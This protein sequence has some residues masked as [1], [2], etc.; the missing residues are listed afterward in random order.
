M[1]LAFFV[2]RGVSE[3][4][5]LESLWNAETAYEY[6]VKWSGGKLTKN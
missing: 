6:F 1:H 5:E 4:L 2:M 3:T